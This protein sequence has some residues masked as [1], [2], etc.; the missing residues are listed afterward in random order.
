MSESER[1]PVAGVFTAADVR[2]LAWEKIGLALQPVRA[3]LRRARYQTVSD[4]HQARVEIRK[5]RAALDLF[6]PAVRKRKAAALQDSLRQLGRA[7]GPIRDL[8]V[9]VERC[10]ASSPQRRGE[11]LVQFTYRVA[12]LR[13]RLLKPALDELQE[14]GRPKRL[15]LRRDDLKKSPVSGS[16]WRQT[17]ESQV[18]ATLQPLATPL[19][20]EAGQDPAALDRLHERRKQC[21]QLRYQLEFLQL[22]TGRDLASRFFRDAQA[23][24]G[25]IQDVTVIAKRLPTEWSQLAGRKLSDDLLRQQ[26]DERA[27]AISQF[28]E[29]WHGPAGWSL[30][31][32]CVLA[33]LG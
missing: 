6:S 10:L 32:D 26:L 27:A 24:L 21:R 4:I 9:L 18:R 31:R 12:E 19:E 33:G 22:A 1:P 20:S 30:A 13:S 3:R 15:R 7:L 28:R 23:I 25:K 29:F 16:V 5:A 14:R 8:D 11:A 2:P 17:L